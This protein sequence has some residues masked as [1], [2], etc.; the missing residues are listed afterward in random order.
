MKNLL[1]LLATLIFPLTS[2]VSQN[3]ENSSPFRIVIIQ[4]SEKG[5][6]Q[7]ALPAMQEFAK[8]LSKLSQLPIQAIYFNQEKKALQYIH[9]KKP[10]LA[11]LSFPFFLKY[12]QTFHLQPHLQVKFNQTIQKKYFIFVH[13]KS[14]FHSLSDLKNK[15]IVSNHLYEAEFLSLLFFSQKNYLQKHYKLKP[16]RRTL[17]ALRYL[18]RQ[19]KYHAIVLD[20][21][22]LKQLQK[23]IFSKY[24]QK[25]R[26]IASSPPIPSSPVAS[27][28]TPTPQ[29][30]K[31]LLALSSLQKLPKGKKILRL[32]GIEAFVPIK[33]NLFSKAQKLWLVHLYPKKGEEK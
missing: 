1:Y 29:I 19:K 12:K 32:F 8:A 25:L 33:K 22:Q 23:P 3:K 28:G 18:T 7:E 26:P 9:K 20:N 14:P 17:R 21:Y 5:S 4:P 24:L 30:Q 2:A 15:T 16:T 11:I 31:I 13:K 6:T 27:F 10:H